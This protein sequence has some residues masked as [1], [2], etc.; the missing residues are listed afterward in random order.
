MSRARG[1]K[2]LPEQP[3]TTFR[4]IRVRSDW[5][6]FVSGSVIRGPKTLLSGAGDVI[7]LRTW[8]GAFKT[9]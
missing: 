6:E 8:L 4:V 5:I 3:R 9:A 7:I 2:T 1:K